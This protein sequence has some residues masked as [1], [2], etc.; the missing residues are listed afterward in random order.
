MKKVLHFISATI[1]GGVVFLFPIVIVMVILKKAF[2]YLEI[3]SSPLELYLQDIF[4][5]FDGHNLFA[6]LLLVLL[7]FMFGII[8]HSMRMRRG[9]NYLE[10]N[11]LDFIPGYIL[12]KSILQGRPNME[13]QSHLKPVLMME[14]D[15]YRPGLMLE[16]SDDGYCTVFFGRSKM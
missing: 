2:D 1:T 12:F 10:T 15:S 4:E 7:C 8:F 16:E 13:D 3:I 9:V 6:I 5:G 14:G 11:L